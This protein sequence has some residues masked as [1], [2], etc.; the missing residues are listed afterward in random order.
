MY[1]A[2]CTGCRQPALITRGGLPLPQLTPPAALPALHTRRMICGLGN[3]GPRYE[4]NRHNV[5]FMA[6]DALARQEGIA[7][8]RL[9]VCRGCFQLLHGRLW[10]TVHDMKLCGCA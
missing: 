10:A 9:Q 4:D 2:C 8:D 5:G 3:P 7:V 6:V 1:I